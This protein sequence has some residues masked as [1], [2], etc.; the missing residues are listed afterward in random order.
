MNRRTFIQSTVTISFFSG[1]GQ[2]IN[3][4]TPRT[5]NINIQSIGHENNTWILL[6]ELD[7]APLRVEIPDIELLLFNSKGKKQCEHYVGTLSGGRSE[8]RFQCS[9]FPEII[10]ART[11]LD[12]EETHTEIIHWV[13]TE[14]EKSEYGTEIQE[15]Q[16][17]PT[18]SS[19]EDIR[20]ETTRRHCDEKLPPERLLNRTEERHIS[21]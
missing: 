16:G 3:S 20:W 18:D 9:E 12:C 13:G 4:P 11:S 15:E 6:L 17:Y 10:S 1:C 8:V 14:E 5:V 7:I 19:L 2:P 21:R